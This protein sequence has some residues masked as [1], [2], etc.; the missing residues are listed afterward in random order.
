ME[1][2][3]DPEGYLSDCFDLDGIPQAGKVDMVDMTSFAVDFSNLDDN[4]LILKYVDLMN[5]PD[6]ASLERT[7]DTL[8]RFSSE[9]LSTLKRNATTSTQ[10]VLGLS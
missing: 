10:R 5:L 3:D 8:K 4:R 6:T 9:L 7:I 1:Q 2:N